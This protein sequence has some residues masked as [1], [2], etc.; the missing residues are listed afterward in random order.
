MKG[1]QTISQCCNLCNINMLHVLGLLLTVIEIFFWLC[2]PPKH[3]LHFQML[4]SLFPLLFRF[5]SLFLLSF[6]QIICILL[7][8]IAMETLLQIPWHHLK[9]QN[10]TSL[11]YFVLNVM[12]AMGLINVYSVWK[13]C[14]E[15]QDCML[16]H[17]ECNSMIIAPPLVWLAMVTALFHSII[18]GESV[19]VVNNYASVATHL[20]SSTTAICVPV[21]V[22][23][24]PLECN[25]NIP[26]VNF[27]SR[28]VTLVVNLWLFV[29]FMCLSISYSHYNAIALCYRLCCTLWMILYCY[30]VQTHNIYHWFKQQLPSCTR[31]FLRS[32]RDK[33]V[34][35]VWR[36]LRIVIERRRRRG[37]MVDNQTNLLNMLKRPWNT[38][39][40]LWMILYRNTSFCCFLATSC[41]L[42]GCVL[43]YF[44]SW[45]LSLVI[46]I[47]LAISI[48]FMLI[49]RLIIRR[50]FQTFADHVNQLMAPFNN[51]SPC[52]ISTS[53]TNS[54]CEAVEEEFEIFEY[55]PITCTD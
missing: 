5:A 44:I 40:S 11:R 35:K 47:L 7:E 19:S 42:T 21:Q 4:T 18:L 41:I 1:V 28:S 32:V 49:L 37:S 33:L 2:V 51:N 39:N 31:P 17:L 3:L 23:I 53:G 20:C 26:N 22:I 36:N 48:Y 14:M 6:N 10:V 55:N 54:F 16:S 9:L 24:I 46:P 15:V 25:R 50:Y 13:I 38:L 8:S 30:P 12:F 43:K 34:P 29:H 45:D 52:F 27:R